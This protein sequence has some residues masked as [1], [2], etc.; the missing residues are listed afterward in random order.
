MISKKYVGEL[1]KD[2]FNT[3]LKEKNLIMTPHNTMGG[4][5]DKGW[6]P[7]MEFLNKENVNVFAYVT[8]LPKIKQKQKQT[9]YNS[10]RNWTRLKKVMLRKYGAKTDL[11]Y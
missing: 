6:F 1:N 8:P 10:D 7:A 4:I 11:I 2:E 9:K 3:F 5:T